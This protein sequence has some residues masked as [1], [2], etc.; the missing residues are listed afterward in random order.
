MV[1][2]LSRLRRKKCL[3]R[4]IVAAMAAAVIFG[5]AAL[6]HRATPERGIKTNEDRVEYL[7][8]LGWSVDP[9]PLSITQLLLP[10]PFPEAL[11]EYNRLQQRQGFDLEKLAG[12]NVTM[13][14]YHVRNLPEDPNAQCSLYVYKDRIA[15]GDIHSVA[16][17][18][19]MWEMKPMG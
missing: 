3:R 19:F 7:E 4:I 15:G 6:R 17:D 18:G 11:K 9:E 12:E 10:D 2:R 8:K 5:I 16:L 13:Y 1:Q 14:T